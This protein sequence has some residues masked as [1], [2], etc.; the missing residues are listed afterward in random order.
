MGSVVFPDAEVKFFVEVPELERA[1][2][3]MQQLRAKGISV[4]LSEVLGQITERDRRDSQR[5]F[6][7]AVPAGE[8]V[9]VDN[10]SQGGRRFEGV[11][12]EMVEH[13]LRNGLVKHK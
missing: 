5:Q 8:A 9:K 1:G 13:C 4:E 11:V 10:S 12:A 3:R 6:G 7:P 2:R